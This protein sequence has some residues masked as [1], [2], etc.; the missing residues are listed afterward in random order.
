[1][2]TQL[3][4][5][6]ERFQKDM[7]S[8]PMDVDK[9]MRQANDSERG[10]SVFVTRIKPAVNKYQQKRLGAKKGKKLEVAANSSFVLSPSDATM[11]RALAA[12]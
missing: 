7:Q 8:M 11:H 1:M 4:L 6:H 3:V 2:T 10:E 9:E 5:Q 12:R